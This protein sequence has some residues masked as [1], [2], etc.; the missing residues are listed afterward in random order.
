MTVRDS[1][2]RPFSQASWTQEYRDIT[3]T[4]QPERGGGMQHAHAFFGTIWIWR[5]MSNLIPGAC[6]H[7][8]G[9]YERNYVVLKKDAQPEHRFG[10]IQLE[11]SPQADSK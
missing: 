5:W 1:G 10:Y 4:V 11:S 6:L 7:D 8:G 3:F 2:D 9:F